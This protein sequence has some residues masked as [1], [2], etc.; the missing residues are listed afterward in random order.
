MGKADCKM[1]RVRQHS[2]SHALH[3]PPTA[4]ERQNPLRG[5]GNRQE[6]CLVKIYH[7]ERSGCQSQIHQRCHNAWSAATLLRRC[8]SYSDLSL[9]TKAA[10]RAGRRE[11]LGAL[12]MWYSMRDK[13]KKGGKTIYI[14]SSNWFLNAWF[15]MHNL[16]L[17]HEHRDWHSG[18][19][20]SNLI[21]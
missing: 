17:S 3:I 5:V 9:G 10:G 11:N 20:K 6:F 16:H 13:K 8:T 2:L 15:A 18:T 21:N 12:V 4:S 19:N 14:K 7:K 1:Y